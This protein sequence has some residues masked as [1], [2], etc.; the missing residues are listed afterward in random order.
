MK[1]QLVSLVLALAPAAAAQ[2]PVPKD[3]GPVVL[4]YFRPEHTDP[5]ALT[6][7][8]QHLVGAQVSFLRLSGTVIV[9]GTAGE[10]KKALATLQELDRVVGAEGDEMREPQTPLESFEYSPRHAAATSIVNALRPY[11]RQITLYGE[12][13]Q[14]ASG[15]VNIN[16]V[17]ERS[18]I[19]VRDT[20]EN[21][22]RIREVLERTD[23]P[24]PQVVVTCSLVLGYSGERGIPLDGPLPEELV[25]NLKR[26]LPFQKYGLLSAGLLRTAV[27]FDDTM[28]IY[29]DAGPGRSFRLSMKPEAY[30]GKTGDLTLSSCAF[31]LF[32]AGDSPKESGFSTRATIRAGEYT[33]LGAIGSDP[34]FVVLRL[35]K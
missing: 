20:S 19:V 35:E 32:S 29:G 15:I 30:D 23:V 2:E 1:T 22:A 8:A 28:R 10:A 21:V 18:V 4:F 9:R 5:G 24:Q 33:V 6:L 26:L 11:Q 27:A 14:P 25:A 17:P 31:E 7:T 12:R 3:E 16:V 13:G 34:V